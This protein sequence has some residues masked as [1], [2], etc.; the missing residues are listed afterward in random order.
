MRNK[1]AKK[2]GVLIS[3]SFRKEQPKRF[4]LDMSLN[5]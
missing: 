4:L 1:I 2:R 5:I 3:C